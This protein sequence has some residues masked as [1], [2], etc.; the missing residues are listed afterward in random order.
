[1]EL[2]KCKRC[3]AMYSI[4]WDKDQKTQ[5]LY[6]S[7]VDKNVADDFLNCFKKKSDK[8]NKFGDE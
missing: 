8:V 1:M 4:K 3:G 2:N 7:A 6:P 5:K